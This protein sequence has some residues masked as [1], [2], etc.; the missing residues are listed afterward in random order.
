M[1][2]PLKGVDIM[3]P[4]IQLTLIFMMLISLSIPL[5]ARAAGVVGR[6]TQVTGQVDL[7]KEGKVPAIAA[8]VQDGVEQGDVIR[9]KSGAKAQLTMVDDSIITMAPDSRLAIADYQYNPAREERR[10]VV[11]I[12]RGLVQTVVKRII[13]REQPDFV[14]ET[15][16]AVTGVRGSNPY[17]LLLPS[18]TSVYLPQGLLQVKSSNPDIP[19]QVLLR[20]R[21][22]TQ[23]RLNQQP[24]LPQPLTL[25]MLRLLEQMMNTGI[26][27]GF[28]WG[29]P[30]AGPSGATGGVGAD[31]LFKSTISPEQKIMQQ[32]IP[33]TVPRPT[34]AAPPPP[35]AQPPS[36][37]GPSGS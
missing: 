22:F 17:F 26:T 14:I 3:R 6:F 37:S 28:T 5:A 25:E 36:P 4:K 8:K 9:T 19:F 10:A 23:V 21:Q 35:P 32:T 15:H 31:F 2:I 24:M 7:L 27:P 13:R 11:R 30:P 1:H 34:P 20:D 16:T 18:L 12:F 29:G 33:P